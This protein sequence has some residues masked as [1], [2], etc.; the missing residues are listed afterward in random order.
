MPRVVRWPHPTHSGTTLYHDTNDPAPRCL[1][2]PSATFSSTTRAADIK[3]APIGRKD[4]ILSEN[5][6]PGLMN[7]RERFGKSQPLKGARVAGCL[8]MT[9]QT[10][11]LI[12]TLTALGAEVRL[13]STHPSLP[14][15]VGSAP[16]S[17][18]PVVSTHCL[19]SLN[20]W[21]PLEGCRRSREPSPLVV[22]RNIVASALRC[23]KFP[24]FG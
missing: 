20:R 22:C 15:P 4:I 5:E 6:M 8:H 3:L 14:T 19:F 11:V 24:I 16:S 1:N 23:L 7:L 21:L 13:P 12:E 10:A 18:S 2:V 17:H 9:T